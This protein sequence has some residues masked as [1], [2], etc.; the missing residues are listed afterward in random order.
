MTNLQIGKTRGKNVF[1]YCMAFVLLFMLLL[2]PFWMVMTSL[3]SGRDVFS[4]PPKFLFVPTMENFKT[5]LFA[6]R[7]SS[8]FLNTIIVSVAATI[9]AEVFGSMAAYSIARYKT[10]GKPVLYGTLIMRVLPPIVLGLPLFIMFSKVHLID[11]IQGLI[12][13]YVGFLLPNTIWL[14]ISFFGG[15]PRSIEEAATIDGCSN[16]QSFLLVSLPLA[17]SGIIVTLVYNL[18]GAWNHF[19]YA[20]T[21]APTKIR[22]LSVE[23]SQYVGEYAVRWGQVAAIATILVL[24][25]AIMTF[26]AQNYLVSGLSLGGVKG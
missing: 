19:F 20:L 10:G 17:R 25:P 13:A 26:F 14:L 8:I 16:F 22:L 12:L 7:F 6:D 5:I 2:P 15:I 23:A 18:T 4:I 21:L 9:L 3:K 24:V 1:A 11:T